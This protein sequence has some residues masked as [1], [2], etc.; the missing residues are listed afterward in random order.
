MREMYNL[1]AGTATS[2]RSR[3]T[4]NATSAKR[5]PHGSSRRS[6]ASCSVNVH[7]STGIDSSR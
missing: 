2:S 4:K 6:G 5:H 3:H 1:A 7:R